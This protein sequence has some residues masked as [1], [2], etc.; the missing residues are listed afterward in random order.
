MEIR[1]VSINDNDGYMFSGMIIRMY[2]ING[3][4]YYYTTI[5]L[6][7]KIT[8][9]TDDSRSYNLSVIFFLCF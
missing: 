7:T 3:Q 4:M 9:Q 5:F 6:K 2:F 8:L 1:D